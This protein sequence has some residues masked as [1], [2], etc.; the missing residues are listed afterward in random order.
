MKDR[1]EL[2]LKSGMEN[3]RCHNEDGAPE[4]RIEAQLSMP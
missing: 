4:T 1:H 2:M 3:E